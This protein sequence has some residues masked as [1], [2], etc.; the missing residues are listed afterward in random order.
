VP[1]SVRSANGASKEASKAA[2]V[3]AAKTARVVRSATKNRE[4]LKQE[5]RRL[6]LLRRQQQGSKKDQNRNISDQV[7]RFT[8]FSRRRRQIVG[9]AIAAVTSLLLLLL[10]TWFTPILA[11]EKVEISGLHR[12]KEK[13]IQNTLANLQGT[14]L[15]LL[16]ENQIAQ[17]LKA[18]PLIESFST[19]SLPPHTLQL[20]I[21]ERQPIA[22][23]AVGKTNYLYDP[24]GVQ[25][26]VAKSSDDYP[27]VLITGDPSKSP[28]F[29]AAVDVMLA[30]PVELANSIQTIEAITKDNVMLTLKGKVYRSVIWGGSDNSVLK[31][32]VLT[33]LMKTTK[34][35]AAVT[36]DVSSPNA[37]A[38]RYSNF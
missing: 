15:T 22:I 29:R 36:F 14:P 23:V 5:H 26:G 21:V 24:A 35:S 7:K 34:K 1:N 17:R 33:A 20:L 8:A 30:L 9:S 6:D 13:S 16:D 37:P 3:K 12:L 11:I 18:F 19:V 31:S 28:N 10:A 2:K 32:K 27:Q 25:I 38:V 4:L